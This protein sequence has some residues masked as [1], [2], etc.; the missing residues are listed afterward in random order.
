MVSA[1][2]HIVLVQSMSVCPILI[3]VNTLINPWADQSAHGVG[4]LHT[5]SQIV[6]VIIT[7][8]YCCI[9]FVAFFAVLPFIGKL[10]WGMLLYEIG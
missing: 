7:F 9:V 6:R 2:L 3:I 4:F 10:C 1:S 8:F 5:N